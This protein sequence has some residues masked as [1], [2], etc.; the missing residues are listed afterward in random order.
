MGGVATALTA[1]VQGAMALGQMFGGGDS[2]QSSI[3]NSMAPSFYAAQGLQQQNIDLQSKLYGDQANAILQDAAEQAKLVQQEGR[4]MVGQHSIDYAHSGVQISGTPLKV[5]QKERQMIAADVA[6]IQR[7]GLA[8]ANLLR[9]QGMIA[10]NEGRAQMIGSNMNFQAAR[11]QA[12]MAESASSRN[13]F[14]SG[15]GALS[16]VLQGFGGGSSGGGGMFSGLGRF[17]GGGGS[18]PNYP[19]LGIPGF[20]PGM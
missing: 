15:L 17:F 11:Q 12:A 10:A 14:M 18:L 20:T 4:R 16:N 1:G 19:P 2:G 5:L 3:Y 7:R 9:M 6:S 13:N 8:Q